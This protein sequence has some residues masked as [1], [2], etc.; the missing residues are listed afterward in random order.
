M[1][2]KVI[3]FNTRGV[4][5]GKGVCVYL[6]SG[7]N[8]LYVG[9]GGPNR[10][11]S[12][13]QTFKAKEHGNPYMQNIVNK[14][15][16]DQFYYSKLMT[17]PE[18][19]EEQRWLIENS[20][21]KHFDTFHNGYNLREFADTPSLGQ[22]A[23]NLGIP[24]SEERKLAISKANKGRKKSEAEI[25]QIRER[26]KGRK[27][28][29]ETKRKLSLSKMGDKNP[30]FG[31]AAHNKGIPMSAEQKIKLSK[32]LLGREVPESVR[33]KTYKKYIFISPTGEFV[34]VFGLN[35]FCKKYG[36]NTGAMAQVAKNNPKYPA[37]KGWKNARK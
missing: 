37:H 11:Y 1:G 17:I 29:E 33:E 9:T 14:Y 12:H 19:Y 24:C 6:I 27:H 26:M 20:Y 25:Q 4:S 31:K 15:G 7:M 28:S 30:A 34:E 32:A 35:K 21:I 18:E 2:R 16:L 36:L 3:N 5:L 22:P 8:A 13:R 10:I 23:W